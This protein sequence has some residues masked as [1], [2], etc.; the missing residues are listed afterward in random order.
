MRDS[1]RQRHRQREKQTP[2]REPNSGLNPRTPGSWSELKAEVQPLS[3]SGVPINFPLLFMLFVPWVRNLCP[4]QVY[5]NTLLGYLTQ[6]LLFDL[7][8]LLGNYFCV[9]CAVKVKT[10]F[11]PQTHTHLAPLHSLRSK[12]FIYV[13]DCCFSTALQYHFYNKSRI[14]VRILIHFLN[15]S[16]A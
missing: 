12:G 9:C 4:L 3:H 7:S 8:H 2:S 14:H 5:L 16:L 1:E 15:I 11:F 13:K 6:I 10:H